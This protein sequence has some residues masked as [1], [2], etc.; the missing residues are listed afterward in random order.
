L[1]Q[2]KNF[3]IR[4]CKHIIIKKLIGDLFAYH[5]VLNGLLQKQKIVLNTIFRPSLGKGLSKKNLTEITK[6]LTTKARH[7]KDS[8]ESICNLKSVTYLM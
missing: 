3:K 1:L 5:R 7:R 4:E 2:Y 8:T 6:F